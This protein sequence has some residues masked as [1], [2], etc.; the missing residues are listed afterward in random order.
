MTAWWT[1]AGRAVESRRDDRLFVDPFAA[2]LAGPRRLEE[3]TSAAAADPLHD[4][5]AVI[6][7]YFDDLVLEATAVNGLRQVVLVACGLD[8]RAFRL[9]WAAGVQVFEVDQ[10]HVITY[11]NTI[12][13][14]AGAVPRCSRHTIGADLTGAWIDD[15]IVSGFTPGDPTVWLLE[16]CLYFFDE[17]TVSAIFDGIS[18]L[19]TAGSRIGFDIV[20]RHVLTSPATREWSERMTA[21]GTPWLF[22][23]DEPA[24]CLADARWCIQ[25]VEPGEGP[26]DFGRYPYPL[27]P[28]SAA[29][30]PRSLL[31]TGAK[32]SD[33]K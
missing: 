9:P 32:L 27:R 17:D 10:P 15:L 30:A 24:Q 7:R 8:A 20:N 23:L 19:S 12:L 2:V 14:S 22:T 11:K 18:R 33:D 5:H 26:A 16:E 13:S 25:S 4:L 1:T 28:K 3:Y 29:T 6:T 31:V 21:A